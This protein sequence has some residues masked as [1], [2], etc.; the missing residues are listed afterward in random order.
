M[1][2]NDVT[3]RPFISA[4][5]GIRILVGAVIGLAGLSVFVFTVDE[6]APEWAPY[7]RIR[8]L[9]VTP[10]AGAGAGVFYHLMDYF[11]VQGGW[12]KILANVVAVIVYVV[13][14]WLGVILGLDGTMWN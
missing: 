5:L 7:W 3:T 14:L 1:Q 11:R 10:L 12:K 9:I 8:P 2:E 4:S 6:A 13:V